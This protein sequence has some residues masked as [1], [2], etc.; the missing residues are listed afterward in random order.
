MPFGTWLKDVFEKSLSTFVQFGLTLLIAGQA[1]DMSFAHQLAT[2]GLA[3]VWV[4]VLNAIPALALP[5]EPPWADVAARAGKSFLQAVLALVVAAGSG[6][7][8]VSVWQGALIAGV[9][10]AATIVKGALAIKAKPDAI[11]PAS[12]AKAA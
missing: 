10:A 4:V 9:V 6:W 5:N 8:S 11:S 7:L 12:L 2:A 1:I 3:A